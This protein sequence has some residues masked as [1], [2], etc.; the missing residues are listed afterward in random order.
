MVPVGAGN[1]GVGFA[2]SGNNSMR[3]GGGSPAC[4]TGGSNCFAGTNNGG[5]CMNN[6]NGDIVEFAP[7][8]VACYSNIQLSVAYRTHPLCAGS[9]GEGLDNGDNLKFEVSLN[10]GAWTTVATVA[11]N[12]NCTWTYLDSPVQCGSNAAVANPYQYAVP[13]GTQTV[14]FRVR[15]QRNRSDEVFYI[16]NIKLTGITNGALGPVSIQH[17]N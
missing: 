7:V 17:I 6:S 12:N 2:A 15:I 8:N 4:G 10:G 13:A 1:Y 11:G 16:D 14:A 9:S 5:T 3:A